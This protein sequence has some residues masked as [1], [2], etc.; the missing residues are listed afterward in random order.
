M[1]SFYKIKTALTP[2]YGLRFYLPSGFLSILYIEKKVLSARRPAAKTQNFFAAGRRA[3]KPFLWFSCH[4]LVTAK[5]PYQ[6]GF[7]LDK[8]TA[9]LRLS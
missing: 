3:A 4:T 7:R 2:V 6:A 5:Q 8:A 9:R 1:P